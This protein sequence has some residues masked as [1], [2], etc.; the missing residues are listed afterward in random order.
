M[1]RHVPDDVAA[2]D[3]LWARVLAGMHDTLE[4]PSWPLHLA[5]VWKQFTRKQRLAAGDHTSGGAAGKQVTKGPGR[6]R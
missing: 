6:G 3:R 1:W 5:A 4:A 2:G